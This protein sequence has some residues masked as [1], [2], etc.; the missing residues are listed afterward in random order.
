MILG[1]CG[2]FFTANSKSAGHRNSHFLLVGSLGYL[3]CE[4]VHEKTSQICGNKNVA[5]PATSGI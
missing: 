1:H 3:A 5:A 4:R 2:D